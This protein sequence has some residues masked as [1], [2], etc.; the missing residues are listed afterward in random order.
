M[1]TLEQARIEIAEIINNSH[2]VEDRLHKLQDSGYTV[3]YNWVKGRIGHIFYL[4][5][6]KIIEYKFQHLNCMVKIIRLCVLLVQR[7]CRTHEKKCCPRQQ[8]LSLI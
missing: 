4:Q 7:K 3:D 6:I 5:H 8:L 1:K 2:L